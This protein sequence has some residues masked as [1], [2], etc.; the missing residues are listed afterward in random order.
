MKYFATFTLDRDND[1]NVAL[2]VESITRT[3]PVLDALQPLP[4]SVDF[5]EGVM[6]LN[7]EILPVVNLKKDSGSPPPPGTQ[8]ARWLWSRSSTSPAAFSLTTSKR[9]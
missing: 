8:K 6:H 2:A 1:I 7:G 9:F 5:L 3:I 4:G